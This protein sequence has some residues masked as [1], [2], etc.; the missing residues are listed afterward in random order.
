MFNEVK[1]RPVLPTLYE[2]LFHVR[3]MRETV[4]ALRSEL[5]EMETSRFLSRL[6]NAELTALQLIDQA[7]TQRG[8]SAH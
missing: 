8:I 7:E 3:A 4:D 5:E 2:A 6:E 1:R